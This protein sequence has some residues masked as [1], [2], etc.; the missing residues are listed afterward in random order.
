MNLV[1]LEVVVCKQVGDPG[2][3]DLL[4][5]GL[6]VLSVPVDQVQQGL[7]S[8]PLGLVLVL[9]LECSRVS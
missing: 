2:M 3:R 9:A 1:R 6:L 5:F 4:L 7:K 8:L